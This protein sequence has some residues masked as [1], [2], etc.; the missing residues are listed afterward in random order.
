MEKSVSDL[1]PMATPLD[2]HIEVVH[3]IKL[4]EIMIQAGP[5]RFDGP[6]KVPLSQLPLHHDIQDGRRLGI[7]LQ[8]WT[9][10][11]EPKAFRGH[12]EPA[13]VLGSLINR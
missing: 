4:P 5:V 2:T 1:S 8:V 6:L 7:P 13:D 12:Q 9:K 11:H 10:K 3:V